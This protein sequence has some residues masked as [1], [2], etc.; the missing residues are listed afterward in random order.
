MIDW[1]R[2]LALLNVIDCSCCQWEKVH[3]IADAIES[4]DA[5]FT[6]NTDAVNGLNATRKGLALLRHTPLLPDASA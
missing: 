4:G 3:D 5:V 1:L 6:F 2:L